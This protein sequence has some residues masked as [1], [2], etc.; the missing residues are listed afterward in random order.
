MSTLAHPREAELDSAAIERLNACVEHYKRIRSD[1]ANLAQRVVNDFTSNAAIKKL[2]HSWRFREKDPEHLREKLVRKTIEAKDAGKTFDVTPENLTDEIDDLAGVRL[3]HINREQLRDIHPKIIEIAK[4]H[5]Y[6][7]R[8]KPIA[9]T[10]DAENTDF[11]KNIG[12][13]IKNKK[14]MY[15]S[16][17]YVLQPHFDNMSCEL[18]V[19]T[20]AEEL[21]GEVSHTV[22]YPHETKSVACI[23]QLA[24]LAR[25]AWGCTRLVDSIFASRDEYDDSAAALARALASQAQTVSVPQ[26]PTAP[27]PVTGPQP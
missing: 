18:Q 21:W 23:Q 24:V 16:V 8:E 19:R 15:T 26:S 13:K 25:I 10:W 20:I 6:K 12:L 9:Y 1:Y 3:L 27:T 5:R 22:N 14:S 4:Y 11:Y 17:H 2:V 7:F